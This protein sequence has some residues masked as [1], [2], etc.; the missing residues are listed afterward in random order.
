MPT[1][2]QILL[3]LPG[4]FTSFS[5]EICFKSTVIE[6]EFNSLYFT[7]FI[8]DN[9]A[10]YRARISSYRFVNYRK[11]SNNRAFTV[12]LSYDNHNPFNVPFPIRVN[13]NKLRV[14]INSAL[15]ISRCPLQSSDTF[16]CITEFC[17]F[18]QV[19]SNHFQSFLVTWILINCA[20]LNI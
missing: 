8:L 12:L 19:F 11:L 14:G 18:R 16:A 6:P 20:D 17:A 7:V 10:N 2:P 3:R 1:F 5:I 13:S 4:E 9:C 15:P